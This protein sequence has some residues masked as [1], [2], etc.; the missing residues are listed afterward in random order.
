ML[1]E[2]LYKT[3]AEEC[4]KRLARPTATPVDNEQ[5][6]IKR[7]GGLKRLGWRHRDCAQYADQ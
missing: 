4:F 5:A 2:R 7:N 6:A 3:S 1:E